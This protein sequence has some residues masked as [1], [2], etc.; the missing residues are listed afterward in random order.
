MTM[1]F[2]GARQVYD[3]RQHELGHFFVVV[4]HT[5]QLSEHNG[6]RYYLHAT[7]LHLTK[8]EE[9][10]TRSNSTIETF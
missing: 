6:I 1:G 10:I 3:C 8:P 2:W 9:E 4:D 7:L 5:K